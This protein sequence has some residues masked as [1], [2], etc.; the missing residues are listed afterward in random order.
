[1]PGFDNK[2][3]KFYREESQSK[4][5]QDLFGGDPSLHIVHHA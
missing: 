3:Q 1:M 4:R 2:M 5:D